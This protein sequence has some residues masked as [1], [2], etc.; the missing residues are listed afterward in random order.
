MAR[1]LLFILLLAVPALAQRATAVGSIGFT[2]SDMDRSV[3]FYRDVLS[4]EKVSDT[5]T[6]GEDVE[7]L[8]GVFGARI[9]TVTMRLGEETIELTE[10]LTP[11]GRPIPDDSRSNDRWFQH[12]AIVVSDMDAAYARLREH[13]VEHVSTAPQRIPDSNAAAAGIRA[14]YFRDPDDHNLEI[15]WFPRGKGDERWQRPAARI[16]LGIDH[17]ALVVSNTNASLLFYRDLLGLRVAG[18]SHNL[19]T[20]QAHLN[21]VEGAHLHISGLRAPGGAGVE[22]LD[23][24]SPRDGR[25]YEG[26]RPNDVVHWQT[27]IAVD[28]LEA[29]VRKLREARATFLSD[30]IAGGKALVRDPD[31]HAILLSRQP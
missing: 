24:L 26:F 31:G 20:E 14:F 8:T 12:I 15:I 22:F 11:K 5:E 18:E 3:A 4:F 29:M 13:K 7:R 9:R 28:D 21:L 19:G 1:R 30:G 17:T 27:A 2:V 25:A 10:F 23:Y 6:W 16:F